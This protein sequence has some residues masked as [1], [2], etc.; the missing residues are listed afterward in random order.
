M[1]S[2]LFVPGDSE[3]K[4]IKAE[5]S[6]ADALV[7]DL[8]DAV[9]AD[10]IGIARGMVREYLSS[11]RD[12]TRTQLWVRINPLSDEKALPDLAAIVAGTPDGILLPKTTSAND[13]MLLDHYLSALEVREG[14]EAGSIRI[15]AVATETAAA[16]FTL[17]GYAGSTKRL[18]G[19][20]WGA[21][22][23]S[24]AVGASTNRDENG[25]LEFTFKLARSLCLLAAKSAD[26]EPIDTVFTNFKDSEALF[27][28]SQAARRAG[29]TGKIA[30]HPDQVEPINRAFTP[31]PEDVEYANR[32]IAAFAAGVGTVG[33]DG[34][35]LDM[36]HLKQAHR[37]IAMAQARK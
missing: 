2:F 12:R 30:I 19:L 18:W 3:R 37:V 24:A 29:F 13:A 1:R 32:V 35:M 34:K 28:E 10:R 22:D 4:F 16:M 36:P 6:A 15:M 33:L 25:D 14:I 17:G 7:L 5:G 27:K 31:S 9:A 20:T 23:L 26:V 11:H 8:E 21:E